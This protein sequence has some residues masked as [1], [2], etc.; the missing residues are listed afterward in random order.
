MM[1]NKLD[2]QKHFWQKGFFSQEEVRFYL[3]TYFGTF[4]LFLLAVLLMQIVKI[5]IPLHQCMPAIGAFI[6]IGGSSGKLGIRNFIKDFHLPKVSIKLS[7]T[8]IVLIY[9]AFL[10]TEFL[11]AITGGQPVSLGMNF[12]NFSPIVFLMIVLGSVGE[13]IGWR[14]YL[15]PRLSERYGRIC[16]SVVVGILW[17]LW[18]GNFY[19]EGLG[20]VFYVLTTIEL[21]IIFTWVFENT[22]R[23]LLN[24]VVLHTAFNTLGLLFS[25]PFTLTYRLISC[26]VFGVIAIAL[27]VN[28]KVFRP[29]L[30]D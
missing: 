22:N 9:F 24:V 14:S 1:D 7:I 4:V 20:F 6:M 30:I 15:L 28:S 26:A 21:S 13:E 27:V 29:D 2:K 23:N 5:E 17:G 12:E 3:L 18:H 10:L 16:G 25:S 8:S 19:G 11:V